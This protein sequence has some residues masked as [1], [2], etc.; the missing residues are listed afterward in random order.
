MIIDILTILPQVFDKVFDESILGAARKNG[1]IDIHIHNLREFGEGRH[2]VLDDSPFGGGPGMVMKA[3]PMARA[4]A[5]IRTRA[6]GAPVIGLTP[7]G[8]PLNQEILKELVRLP[9][10]VLVCGR[11]E[12][13][14]DRIL[15]GFDAEI[16]LGD[17]VIS[18]GEFAAMVMVD[19]LSRLIPGTVGRMES[20]EQD[21]FYQGRLDHP[22]F[23]RPACWQQREV[24]APLTAGN[25]R[26]IESWRLRSSLMRTAIRRPDLLFR[27]PLASEDREAFQDAVRAPDVV[28]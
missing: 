9:R 16:S 18:G 7:Q 2:K 25:H 12:G 28:W 21:S 15:S 4:L 17:Y 19:G 5:D 23:T 1:L 14:D 3:D 22:Q 6:P 27:L 24:P 13:F 10:L 20:V 26:E 8:T 11:Y